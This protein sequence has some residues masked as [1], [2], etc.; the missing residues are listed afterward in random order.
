MK[1]DSVIFDMDGTL[2]D[3][4]G[5]LCDAVN[6]TLRHFGFPERTIEEVRTFVGNGVSVL[7]FSSLP[8]GT[9]EETKAAALSY[10]VDYYGSHNM[11]KTCA[12][13]GVTELLERLR[14]EG[15]PCAIVS[16]KVDPAV[17]EL[18][19]IFFPGLTKTA[20]GEKEGIRRKPAPDSVFAAMEIIGSKKPVYVGDSEV[21]VATAKAAGIDGIFVTW[22]FRGRE[23]LREAGGKV[24][25]DCAE[26][27]YEAL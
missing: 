16:N 17:R 4:L 9:D 15:V 25:V 18:A 3:T 8:E 21:D 1:Y 26:E 6:A 20:I 11:I 12:Y 24:I 22:G 23:L 13:P 2:L 14:D 10:Y 19:E 7:V 5:D 27:L